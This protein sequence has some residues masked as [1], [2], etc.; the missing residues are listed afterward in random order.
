MCLALSQ[1]HNALALV[2]FDLYHAATPTVRILYSI[3]YMQYQ[4]VTF[5][6]AVSAGIGG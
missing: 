6:T 2:C 4:E 5:Y 3:F 1:H